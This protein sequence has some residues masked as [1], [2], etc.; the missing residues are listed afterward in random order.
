MNTEEQHAS[1]EVK[2]DRNKVLTFLLFLIISTILWLLI[3]LTDNYTTQTEFLV[4][5][6]EIPANK[7]MSST[8]QHVK[9]SFVGDGFTTLRHHLVRP[10]KR[11]VTIPL[12][13]VNYRLEGGHT[14]SYGGQYVAER[15]ARWL[16]VPI[17]NVTMSDDKQYFNMEDLQSREVPVRVRYDLQT[18]RQ[19]R[20]Y[21]EPIADP[22]VITVYGPKN[23]LDTLEAIYTSVLKVYNVNSD[24]EREVDLELCDGLVQSETKRVHAT[25]D[26]EQ[27]TETDLEVP[28]T[29]DDTLSVRFFPETMKVKCLIAIKDF[30]QVNGNAFLV[31]ADTAQL[32]A[33][34]PLL[35][36]RLV[37][38][39]KHV[40]VLKTEP[41]VVEYLIVE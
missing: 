5:Y 14:Y 6:T 26:V 21:D 10:H 37:R 29:V 28:V 25:V 34:Q 33:R 17:S 15:V 41:E 36:I 22:A 27:Y 30:A 23:V 7:W 38:A 40:V 18:Q 8:D 19:Y 13:E 20:L 9:L 4:H 31:L 24:V 11:V 12:N 16:D 32:H 35:D 3:K 39:P 1:T 2:R